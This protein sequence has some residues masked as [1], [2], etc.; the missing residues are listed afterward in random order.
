MEIA[1]I[2]FILL[3]MLSA[4]GYFAYL[5][6]Q[7]DYLQKTGYFIL[8][9]GFF[10]H[11]AIIASGFIKTGHF[12]AQNLRE[13][14]MVAGWAIAG[15]F[16]IIQHRFNLKILGVFAAPLVVL[17]VI[18][19]FLLP[20]ETVQTTNIFKNF[21][22]ISHIITIFIGEASLA[23]ACGIGILYL[24]QER[25]IKNKVRGFFFKRL[26]S[27]ELLDTTGYACIVVGFTMLTI[28]LI[29]GLI[30]AKSVWGRFWG[31][32]TKEV[33]AGITW[34]LYAVLL[35]ERLAV[36]WRGRKAAIMAIV[37][38]AVLLFTFFGVNFLLEGHHGV[39]TK[40]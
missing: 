21:W 19:A 6:L 27:L 28:G 24:M 18:G 4:A 7:K 36:G 15:V 23:L 5:F 33:W 1:I 17:V 40:F 39:F 10:F 3:Y 38:F 2:I 22:L 31:W 16:L 35:H 30:Y 25:S 20:G 13:T 29:T 32:D 9:A 12:P 34:V 37:G 26:P 11:T 14:L 8:L